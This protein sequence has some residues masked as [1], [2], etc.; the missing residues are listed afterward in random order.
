MK[1]SDKGTEKQ[2]AAVNF[3]QNVWDSIYFG[4]LEGSQRQG[5]ISDPKIIPNDNG[6]ICSLTNGVNCSYMLFGLIMFYIFFCLGCTLS[7]IN[8]ERPT[9]TGLDIVPS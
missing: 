5:Y 8:L 3:I 1:D 9:K 4:L 6:H 2:S 7:Y